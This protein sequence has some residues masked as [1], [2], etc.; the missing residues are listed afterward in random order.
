MYYANKDR[1][2]LLRVTIPFIVL[3]RSCDVLKMSFLAGV[4]ASYD[5]KSQN[6]INILK[7]NLAEDIV[8]FRSDGLA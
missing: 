4:S 1:K 2:Q 8:H 5:P 3:D 7:E 6:V